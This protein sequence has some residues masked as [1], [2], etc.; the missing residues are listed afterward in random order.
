M[1]MFT[2]LDPI[3]PLKAKKVLLFITYATFY[4]K[5]GSSIIAIPS[6]SIS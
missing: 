5:N 3:L 2:V 4:T 1:Q 6:N